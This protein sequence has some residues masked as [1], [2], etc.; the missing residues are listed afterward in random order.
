MGIIILLFVSHITGGNIHFKIIKRITP[1]IK[2]IKMIFR[3][4]GLRHKYGLSKDWAWDAIKNKIWQ[5][6]QHKTIVG[7]AHSAEEFFNKSKSK[8][9]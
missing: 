6:K 5:Q 4:A 2:I 1:M 8:F 7:Q 9:Q 3:A